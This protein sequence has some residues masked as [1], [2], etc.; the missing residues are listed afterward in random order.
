MGTLIQAGHPP[1]VAALLGHAALDPA[2]PRR[3]LVISG[4]NLIAADSLSTTS[5]CPSASTPSVCCSPSS[6]ASWA[7][8]QRKQ[9]RLSYLSPVIVT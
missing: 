2:L 7:G 8:W 1:V 5:L 6:P 3:K 9:A 4:L